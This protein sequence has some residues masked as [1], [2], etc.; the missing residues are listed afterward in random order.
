MGGAQTGGSSSGGSAGTSSGSAGVDASVPDASTDASS[1]GTLG[2]DASIGDAPNADSSVGICCDSGPCLCDCA[3]QPGAGCFDPNLVHVDLYGDIAIGDYNH[4]GHL[5]II[6]ATGAGV[7]GNGR[8]GFT[9]F[10]VVLGVSPRMV[11]T[12]DYNDDGIDDILVTG[13]ITSGCGSL[14]RLRYVVSNGNGTYQPLVAMNVLGGYASWLETADLDGD[15]KRE[16]VHDLSDYYS[17]TAQCT[18]GSYE[19]LD[20][21][22]QLVRSISAL[23]ERGAFRAMQADSDPGLELLSVGHTVGT[24]TL[25]Y[26]VNLYMNPMVAGP[27][28]QVPVLMYH[29]AFA[30]LDEDGD[31]ELIASSN[32]GQALLVALGGFPNYKDRLVEVDIRFSGV[33]AGGTGIYHYTGDF[34]RDGHVDVLLFQTL[35]TPALV[36]LFGTGRNS[37]DRAVRTP[38]AVAAVDN[39]PT[40]GPWPEYV[41]LDED[42]KLDL[43]FQEDGLP[44]RLAIAFGR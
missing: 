22:L 41:D 1:G 13:N 43:V 3:S 12:F 6:S 30:D 34:D 20:H 9:P 42:G 37:F 2:N 16:V 36:T 39:P 35:D 25:R 7:Y 8:R 15:G 23:T 27:S 31:Y 17:V 4:D 10:N 11:A 28:D 40:S 33:M 38:L 29:P 18:T 32:T 14:E 5:D 21:R 24:G 26:F 19:I 44:D